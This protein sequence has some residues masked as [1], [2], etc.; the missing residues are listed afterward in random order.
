[1]KKR[2][3]KDENYLDQIVVDLKKRAQRVLKAFIDLVQQRWGKSDG[4]KHSTRVIHI[5]EIR[6]RADKRGF[7][8]S[9]DAFP[10]SPL[11]YRGPNAIVDAIRYVKLYSGSHDAV[12]R[13]YD[14]AGNG[15]ET[16]EPKSDFKEW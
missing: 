15:I 3:K 9:G 13:V 4:R 8:L 1:M 16:H 14:A 5:Y 12:I 10:Y 7:D 2:K 6:P 11:W